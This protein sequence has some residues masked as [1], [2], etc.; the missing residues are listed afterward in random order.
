MDIKLPEELEIEVYRCFRCGY[1]RAQCPVF[2]VKQNESW[3]TRGRMILIKSLIE[4]DI[5]ATSAVLDRLYCCSLCK[6]CE[7]SCPALVRASDVYERVRESLVE[8]KQAPL[9]KHQ[10]IAERILAEGN[11]FG[12]PRAERSSSYQH[13]NPSNAELLYFVGCVPSYRRPS[14]VGSVEKIFAAANIEY[15]T[16]GALVQDVI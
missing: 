8:Q 1:C 15:A 6:A 4:G 13:K 14:I 16:L 2:K 5:D 7:T 3:G 12:L 11:P 10:K 9:D